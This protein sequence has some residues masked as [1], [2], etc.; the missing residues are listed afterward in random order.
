[1]VAS[2]TIGRKKYAGVEEESKAI[3]VEATD[4]RQQLTQAIQ[5]DAEAFQAV[6]WAYRDKEKDKGDREAAIEQ[7]MIHAGEVPFSVAKLSSKVAL[8]ADQIA[9]KGNVNAIS[10]AG[11]SAIMARAAVEAAAMNVRINAKELSDRE[12]AGK[13]LAKI[14]HLEQQVNE[15]VAGTVAKVAERGGF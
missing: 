13:W 4:L 8:L 12:L 11:A 7:A 2:L 9:L 1:M 15:V 3:L 14:D 6:M 5:E 10:D